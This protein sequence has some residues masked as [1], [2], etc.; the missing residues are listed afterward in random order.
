[1]RSDHGERMSYRLEVSGHEI[2]L[3]KGSESVALAPQSSTGF[4]GRQH[5]LAWIAERR[6]RL[7][8]PVYLDDLADGELLDERRV[9]DGARRERILERHHRRPGLGHVV[10]AAARVADCLRRWVDPTR[11]AR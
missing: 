1:M 10:A 8:R 6:A 9:D 3:A 7:A 5:D 4:G 11:A 2:S